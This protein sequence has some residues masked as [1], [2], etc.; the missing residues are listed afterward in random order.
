MVFE[1]NTRNKTE[2]TMW[3]GMEN[4]ARKWCFFL[5]TIFWG[6]LG[7]LQDVG[8]HTKRHDIW[9]LKGIA[10]DFV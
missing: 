6:H 8:V 7:V 10:I 2:H 4:C 5:C 1:A 3:K 9:G